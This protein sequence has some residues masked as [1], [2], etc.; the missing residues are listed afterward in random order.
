MNVLAVSAE[1]ANGKIGV[2][3]KAWV[4]YNATTALQEWLS[5]RSV[6]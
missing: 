5:S 3:F 4:S 1:L 2:L 6:K